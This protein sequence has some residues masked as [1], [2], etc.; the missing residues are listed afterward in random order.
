MIEKGFEIIE[1]Y[2]FFGVGIGHFN[3][4]QAELKNIFSD[5]YTRLIGNNL[6][7]EVDEYNRTSAHNSYI[8]V[9]AEMG[10]IGFIVLLMIL[11]PLLTFSIIRLF[12]LKLEIEDMALISIFGMCIHFYTIS[13]FPGTLT[14]F[15]FG[16]ASNRKNFYSK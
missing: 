13:S 10:I 2:P 6:N 11:I 1:K 4:Y 5:D 12:N 9:L 16:L 3:K 14:W 7:N 8:H 15:V